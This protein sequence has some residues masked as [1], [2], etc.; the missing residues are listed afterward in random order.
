MFTT[1]IHFQHCVCVCM[2]LTEL[3]QEVAMSLDLLT[4]PVAHTLLLWGGG[5]GGVSVWRG[6][7]VC[8]GGGA[9]EC[10]EGCVCVCVGGG[11]GYVTGS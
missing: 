8:V 9:G 3:H 6:K 7:C 10:V 1:A 4:R 11:G 5:G 2:Y